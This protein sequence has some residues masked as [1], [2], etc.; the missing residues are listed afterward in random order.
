M[1][2][3]IVGDADE[4]TIRPKKFRESGNLVP[5]RRTCSLQTPT[6]GKLTSSALSNVCIVL[7]SVDMIG[8]WQSNVSTGVPKVG[9]YPSDFIPMARI[10]YISVAR[11]ATASGANQPLS[12]FMQSTGWNPARIPIQAHRLMQ[13]TLAF[14]PS[15]CGLEPGT[16]FLS[17]GYGQ[18]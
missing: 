10:T 18:L 12:V 17:Y 7:H 8:N 15:D 5:G 16:V 3:A 1:T 4:A 6:N 14:H 11:S 9:T 13:E 2:A